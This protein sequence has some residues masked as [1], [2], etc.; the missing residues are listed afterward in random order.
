MIGNDIVDLQYAS[1]QS[2]WQRRGFL[3]KLFT[4]E[5]QFYISNSKD[6]FK[7]VWLLWSMKE[8]V[9]KAYLQKYQS[10]FFAPKKLKCNLLSHTN[11]EVFIDGE[12]FLTNS[13]ITK[14]FIHTIAVLEKKYQNHFSDIFKVVD[15]T[16]NNQ[17]RVTHEKLKFALAS[18][19]KISLY[20]LKIKKN[21][22]GIPQLFKGNMKL[23]TS[24]SLT[25]HGSFGAFCFELL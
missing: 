16:Y 19:L 7:T 11:G 24:L 4:E 1:W 2:N 5:E 22:F 6:K 20:K 15:G 12:I 8:S 17:H 13:K 10:P 25:H 21:I 23:P 18:E 9:Y 14:N 3:N